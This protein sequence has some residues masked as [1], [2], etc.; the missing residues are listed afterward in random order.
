M[1]NFESG[2]N[3][4][5]ANLYGVTNSSWSLSDGHLPEMQTK[6][7]F[8][9]AWL[10]H[11]DFTV[12][13]HRTPNES[14]HYHSNYYHQ[15]RPVQPLPYWQEHHHHS[16]HKHIHWN[17]P[18]NQHPR[19]DVHQEQN[20]YIHSQT[21]H[22]YDIPNTGNV[23]L[24]RDHSLS[25]T[26]SSTIRSQNNKALP[27]S[28]PKQEELSLAEQAR[29][30][31]QLRRQRYQMHHQYLQQYRQQQQMQQQNYYRKDYQQHTL[32][33]YAHYYHPQNHSKHM[34][35]YDF[36]QYPIMHHHLPKTRSANELAWERHCYYQ[37]QQHLEEALAEQKRKEVQSYVEQQGL[38]QDMLH[39]PGQDPTA[40]TV[41]L[42]R[43]SSAS[44]SPNAAQALGLSQSKPVFSISESDDSKPINNRTNTSDKVQD[45]LLP[46][47]E[48]ETETPPISDRNKSPRFLQNNGSK[49]LEATLSKMLAEQVVSNMDS[50]DDVAKDLSLLQPISEIVTQESVT[51]NRK[52]TFSIR[53]L[54]RRCSRFGSRRPNSFAG[55]SNDPIIS[56][57]ENNKNFKMSRF[58]VSELSEA[59]ESQPKLQSM[60]D[61]TKRSSLITPV[62]TSFQLLGAAVTKHERVPVHRKVTL[63]RSEIMAHSNSSQPIFNQEQ[64]V[65]A[66]E[67][68]QRKKSL[69]TNPRDT[70]LRLANGHGVDL[71]ALKS[72]VHP[73]GTVTKDIEQPTNGLEELIPV[74]ENITHDTSEF[75]QQDKA[76]RQIIEL[77]GMGR[78]ERISAKTGLTMAARLKTKSSVTTP[79]LTPLALEACQDLSLINPTSTTNE[80]VDPCEHIAFMLVPKSR[81]EF[82]P[83][84][85]V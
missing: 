64:S 34:S 44:L 73:N 41:S 58:V 67:T 61:V 8:V 53:S 1:P 15:H 50:A 7:D 62:T 17:A 6:D 45:I 39:P 16:A 80:E 38:E 76:R 51:L 36:E 23:N 56:L 4:C 28:P 24:E 77:L 78:K 25:W 27:P 70:S 75:E 31:H 83:L 40:R 57:E 5:A 48:S 13:N 43:I 52:S 29:Q 14:H 12:D 49:D 72:R 26:R 42:N 74:E 65:M 69:S 11:Q 9:E 37:Q 10:S 30:E 20:G 32:G 18:E 71:P 19:Y 63:F 81:Y 46:L 3:I 68:S 85:A 47:K 54:A 55:L 2:H 82:Q 84:V 60:I 21:Q 35:D 33:P 22:R 66:S 79:I 59:L